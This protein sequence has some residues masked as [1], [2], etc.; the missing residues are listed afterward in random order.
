MSNLFYFQKKSLNWI[1]SFLFMS[2]FSFAEETKNTNEESLETEKNWGIAGV[3][4]TASIPYEAE[5]ETVSTFIPMMFFE[6]E[7]VFI[8]GMEGGVYIYEAS[9]WQFSALMR[10]RYFDLPKEVQN[11]AG[12]DVVDTGLQARYQINDEWFF[13][14]EVMVDPEFRSYLNFKL[15]AEISSG[16]WWF[17]PTIETRFKEAEFNNYYY[18][19]SDDSNQSIGSGID[20]K[21]GFMSRY[22]VISNL[23]LLGGTYVSRLDDNAYDS[24]YIDNRWEYEYF[25]GVGFFADNTHPTR[26][27]IGNKPY[28][29]VA[30]GWATPSN[31]G[32]IIRLDSEKDPHN[33]QMT[34]VFYGL[35]LTDELFS[36]PLDLY[37]T[38]G[39][40]QHWESDVQNLSSEF[41]VAIKAYA[42]IPW[43][44][45]WRFGVAEG[46]SYINHV[47]YIEQ[48]EMDRK[49]YRE[50]KLLNYLDFSFDINLG[51]L[52]NKR[53]W[54]SVW[55]GY[56]IHHRS[57]IFE[58]SSQYGR[59]KG[60]SNYNSVY[61]QFDL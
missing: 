30:H 43:P 50:S 24:Q 25:L 14:S 10:L 9:D 13:D 54:D 36:L 15:G 29:R 28:L 23:Y 46:L 40:V 11:K 34:S 31:I 56:S 7:Y 37:L 3:I 26:K 57:A 38:P 55:L 19:L 42:T 20:F 32:D 44:T 45:K 16:D 53:E 59:I 2:F 60:G 49:G 48:T 27:N 41:V 22:H 1:F 39:Y 35:P 12:G 17:N 21:A 6:N 18:G 52:F 47:S 61:L 33:N 5:S 58:N 4:R 51:D 8:N